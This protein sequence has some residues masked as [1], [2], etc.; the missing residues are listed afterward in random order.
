MMPKKKYDEIRQYLA[1]SE[2]PLFMF[3][4]D[5]DGLSSFLTLKKFS[6]KGHGIVI[7]SSP[8]LDERFIS[9]VREYSPDMIFVL[10]KPL[11]SQEFIDMANT[12]IVWIDHHPPVKRKGVKYFNPRLYDKDAYLPTSYICYMATK[13]NLWVAMCGIIGDWCLPEFLD[14]FIKQYP[15]LLSHPK[16]PGDVLYTMEFGRLIRI[17]SFLLKGK[18]SDV[19]KNLGILLRIETPYELLR[20]E[21]GRAKFLYKRFEKANK[22][23]MRLMKNAEKSLTDDKL[24]VFT[25][26][27]SKTSFTGYL[28]TELSYLHPDKIIIIGREKGDEIRMSL[29]SRDIAIEPILKKALV[30][31]DGYGGGHSHACGA[32]IKMSDLNLF[33]ERIRNGVKKVS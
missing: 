16:V 30:G 24:L 2:N 19:N 14:D 11:I 27:P 22:M 28:S 20:Q 12:P 10:N 5:I 26:P 8:E 17:L 3:D 23:Y 31:L 9:K 18:T 25:Y 13:K 1:K 29:R 33:I 32:N 21:T 7:K 4:D 6:D 15:D